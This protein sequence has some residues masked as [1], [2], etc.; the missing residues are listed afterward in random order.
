M[1]V[2]LMF[3][4]HLLLP[5]LGHR[6]LI[7]LHRVLV[8]HTESCSRGL[9]FQPADISGGKVCSEYSSLLNQSWKTL[10]KQWCHLKRLASCE[11][12]K[13]QHLCCQI[14]MAANNIY[15]VHSYLAR[16]VQKNPTI[17]K[18]D[19][20]A[21]IKK[22]FC[23]CHIDIAANCVFIAPL[24]LRDRLQFNQTPPLGWG[25]LKL[26]SQSNVSMNFISI[27][28]CPAEAANLGCFDGF[29]P[30]LFD[31][32]SA[33]TCKTSFN[34]CPLNIANASAK[35]HSAEMHCGY[36]VVWE[37]FVYFK[38]LHLLYNQPSY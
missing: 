1:P 12:K 31:S 14:V 11:V 30:S 28:T 23:V 27:L 13:R 38:V 33:N 2:F 18:A 36:I 3:F 21:V 19:E 17:W 26:L 10:Q 29:S 5:T 22:S 15:A 16:I 24:F 8:A 9:C 4:F 25:F 20:A 37:E 7:C 32:Q 34:T 35:T 6:D